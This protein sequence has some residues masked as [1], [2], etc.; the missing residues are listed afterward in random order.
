MAVPGSSARKAY[1]TMG[2]VEAAPLLGQSATPPSTLGSD[3]RA[4]AQGKL[5]GGGFVPAGQ[6]RYFSATTNST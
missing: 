3:E 2:S 1:T 4:A 5:R 6:E